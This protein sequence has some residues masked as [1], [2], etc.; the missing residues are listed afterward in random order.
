MGCKWSYPLVHPGSSLTPLIEPIAAVYAAPNGGNQRQI[1]DEDSLS[2]EY[3]DTDLFRPDRL[4][5]YDILDTGQRVDYGLK[6]GLYDNSGGSCRALVGQ[7]YRAETN[8]FL[9]PGSGAE[10]R[11]SDIVGR[12]VL[13]PNSYLDLIY[14][15]RLDGNT[16][17][18]REPAGLDQR[19]S[20]QFAPQRQLLLEV[21]PELPSEVAINPATGQPC[22]TASRSSSASRPPP[23][24]PA[25]GRCKAA[26]RST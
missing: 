17:A 20:G 11:L 21:P 5:G 2:F 26:R 4:A 7:S 24:S 25:T 18:N 6:L 10:Q 19:R 16:F 22:F 23:S 1:P 3:D 13:S 8:P 9:P 12:V 14:R 15:F